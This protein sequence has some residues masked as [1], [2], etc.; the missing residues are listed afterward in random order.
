MLNLMTF[1]I[2]NKF[3]ALETGILVEIIQAVQITNVPGSSES[4]CGVINYRGNLLPVI[5]GSKVLGVDFGIPLIQQHMLILSNGTDLIVPQLCLLVDQ[6]LKFESPNEVKNISEVITDTQDNE[7]IEFIA[8]LEIGLVPV[9][10][11]AALIRRF[12]TNAF[13]NMTAN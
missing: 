7:I 10:N 9:L 8:K 4:I 6:V 2:G 1:E 13:T 5:S 3:Y 11:N 12:N